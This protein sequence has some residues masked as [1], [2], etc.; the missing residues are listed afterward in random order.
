MRSPF[1]QTFLIACSIA[2]PSLALAQEASFSDVPSTHSAFTAVEYLKSQGVLQ[3]YADGTF[4]PNQK[5]NRA[6]AIKIIVTPLVTPETISSVKNSAYDDV[7]D[8]TWYVG[9]VEAA[10][11][12]LGM[13]DGPPKATAFHP[14]RPVK[15]SEFIKMLL[16]ADKV[17]VASAFSDIALPLANDVLDPTQW[18]YPYMRYA[19]ASSMTMSDESGNLSPERELTRSDVAI[20]IYR[21]QMFTQKRRT[22]A[23][24]SETETE[25]LNVLSTLEA[26][27]IVQAHLASARSLVAA[28]GALLS[29][30]NEAIVKGAVKTAEGFR[31]LV[32]AYQ[33]G[34]E[35]RLQEA[36]D[37][38]KTA[39]DLGEKARVFAPSLDSVATQM[40]DIAKTVADQAREL[41]K[42]Q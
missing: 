36:I 41:Q 20:L 9:H 3:G 5:V 12:L 22:Q 25:I 32:I 31:A 23:L 29:K 37:G 11:Q 10:R 38:A 40:Q 18:Y 34:S 33:A 27:D 4:H 15:K 2:L 39:W 42:K 7:P 26:K 35:G 13:I 17:G 24:L 6:E 8:T 28:R 1:T 19:L 16:V 21:Y 30:P 14:E